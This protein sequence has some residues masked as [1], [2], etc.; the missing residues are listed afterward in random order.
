MKI[1]WIFLTAFALQ[2]AAASEN[3][4]LVNTIPRPSFTS[5][6]TDLLKHMGTANK[7]VVFDKCH[8]LPWQFLSH[9]VENYSN[10]RIRKDVMETFINDLAQIHTDAAYYNVLSPETQH[11][12]VSLTME[13]TA[14]AQTALNGGNMQELA[15]SLFNMP[16]NL[17]PGDQGNNRSIQNNIDAPKQLAS[18]GMGRSTDATTVA[19][20]LFAKYAPYGLTKLSKPCSSTMAKTADKPPG[21]STGDCV[22]I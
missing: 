3:F 8:I 4:K 7:Y 19:K 14:Y 2:A 20:K 10:N 5:K 18:S 16:S 21:D 12:L 1:A 13:F 9:M 15:K 17:Y 22:T 11:T 6:V